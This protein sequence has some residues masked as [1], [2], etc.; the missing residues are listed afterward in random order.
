MR[1]RGGES[2]GLGQNV[3]ARA[4]GFQRVQRPDDEFV[5]RALGAVEAERADQRTLVAAGVLARLLAQRRG[6]ALGVENVVG[7]LKGRAQRET[8]VDQ[9]GALV[10]SESPA[11]MAVASSKALCTVGRP[12]RRSSSSMAGKS[13]CTSE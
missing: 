8:I 1:A 5:A 12:R 4:E 6:V 3:R 11:R 9:R 13:S 7:D 2:R 10:S